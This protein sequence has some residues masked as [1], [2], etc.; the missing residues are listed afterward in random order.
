MKGRISENVGELL[1]HPETR[2]KLRMILS[3]GGGEIEFEGKVWRIS[4]EPIKKPKTNLFKKV[5]DELEYLI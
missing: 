2:E 5:F 1:K 4:S 3:R